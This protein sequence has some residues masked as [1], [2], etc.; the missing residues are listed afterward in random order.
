MPSNYDQE[1]R[2]SPEYKA[3]LRIVQSAWTVVGIFML[4]VLFF[5]PGLP[6]LAMCMVLGLLMTFGAFMFLDEYH[7]DD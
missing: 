6:G 3:R 1:R 5:Y 2:N 7:I 4:F